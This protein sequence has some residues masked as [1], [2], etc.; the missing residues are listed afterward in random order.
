MDPGST[1]RG[2]ARSTNERDAPTSATG[3]LDNL[4]AGVLDALQAAG[5]RIPAGI[6][7]EWPEALKPR[8]AVGL[9]DDAQV[10]EI[11]ARKVIADEAP[12]YE[13]VLTGDAARLPEPLPGPHRFHWADLLARVFS[14]DAFA[15]PSCGGRMTVRAVVLPGAGTLDV[16]RGLQGAARA[17]PAE[18]LPARA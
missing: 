10:V 17:P 14:V 15:C 5:G 4:V 2:C 12:F 1:P 16:L 6:G 9:L 3:D 13:V 18:E 8:K 7:A 11:N